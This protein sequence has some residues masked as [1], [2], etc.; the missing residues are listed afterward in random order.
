M[1]ES[2]KERGSGSGRGK[3]NGSESEKRGRG[4]E[5]EK[6]RGRENGS[7]KENGSG[8]EK[9][10]EKEKKNESG[11]ENGKIKTKDAMT[12]GR[13]AR[14]SERTGTP[15]ITTRRGSPRSA[16]ETKGVPAPGC[17]PS[18]GGNILQTVTPT[19]VGMTKM[20]SIDS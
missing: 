4:R 20:K 2:E 3:K 8:S 17:P 6:G 1:I 9:G 19:T 16:I 14:M 5:N 13:S 7:G 11:K 18:A 15:E 10:P 12:E